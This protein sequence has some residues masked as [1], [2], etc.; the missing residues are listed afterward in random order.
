M[1]VERCLNLFTLSIEVQ[2]YRLS[3][4]TYSANFN[5]FSFELHCTLQRNKGRFLRVTESGVEH[6]KDKF[7]ISLR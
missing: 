1:R 5:A 6:K 4:N 7:F 2:G 3:L